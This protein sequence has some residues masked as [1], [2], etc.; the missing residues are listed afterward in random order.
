MR[1]FTRFEVDLVGPGWG[2]WR[3]R[4]ASSRVLVRNQRSWRLLGGSRDATEWRS[5]G[6]AADALWTKRRIFDLAPWAIGW[7]GY[8]EC[9]DL[10]GDLPTK[11]W[12]E[13]FPQGWWLIAP[14]S[15]GDSEAPIGPIRPYSDWISSLDAASFRDGVETIRRRISAGDVYQVNLTRRYSR[16]G[17]GGLRGLLTAACAERVPDYAAHFMFPG[18]ELVCSSME[19]LARR[20]GDSLETR[21]I[22]GT[23]PRGACA[24]DDELQIRELATDGKELAELAMVVDLERNDLGRLAVSGT[25]QVVDGGSVVSWATV[26]HRVARV[27]AQISAATPWWDIV[28]VLAPG[29][30]VTG[31]P[32]R[33]AMEVIAEIETV[34]RGPYCG[35]LGV[36][37]GDGSLELALP[38]RTAWRTGEWWHCASGCGIVWGSDPVSEE[39]ESRLKV[40]RWVAMDGR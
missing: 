13:R 7:L 14:A 17:R 33:A 23:R 26:H 38:I 18:G 36:V 2:R 19:L 25:V 34:A 29:G 12:N 15:I 31:C 4:W 28:S 30:S 6:E 11:E 39:M 1:C 32:K 20:R 10:A 35:V 9:A 37:A 3:G 16:R 22:K 21:P 8:E 40:N 5:F 24:V 27:C